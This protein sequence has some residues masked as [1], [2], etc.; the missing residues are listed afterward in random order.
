MMPSAECTGGQAGLYTQ[1]DNLPTQ[2]NP[3]GQTEVEILSADLEQARRHLHSLDS[4][5]KTFIFQTFDDSKD[6]KDPRLAQTFH[7][8]IDEHARILA[9]LNRQGAGIYVTVNC[10]RNGSRKK[11][12]I[13]AARAMYR[14][15]DTPDLPPLPVEPHLVIETSPGKKH[16]Y[17]MHEPTTDFESWEGILQTIVDEHGGDPGAKGRNRV[18]R[19]AGFHHMKDPLHPHQVKIIHKSGAGRITLDELAK[20]IPPARRNGS[21]T[22]DRILKQPKEPA[23]EM[24]AYAKAALN[25]E[26]ER[27]RLAPEGLRNGTLNQAAFSLGQ[28]VAGGEINTTTAKTALLDAAMAAGL[29]EGEAMRTIQS[30]MD[31][32]SKEPRLAPETNRKSYPIAAADFAGIEPARL[33]PSKAEMTPVAG[34]I[35]SAR[36]TP[37]CF[38]KNYIYADVATWAAPG[39]T[40]K[41][42]IS[43]YEAICLALKMPLHGMNIKKT[44]WTLFITAEDRREQ[45][46]ARIREMVNAMSL[47]PDLE[48]KVWEN[49]LIWDVTGEQQRLINL[50]DGNIILTD[51]ADNIVLAHKNDP[52]AL[53]IFDPAIS[54]GVSEG[55]VNDNENGIVLAC[56]RIVKGLD[57]CVRIIAHTGKANAREGT[58]DQYS[59]R[60][61]SALADGS[62]MV[63]VLQ[64]WLPGNPLRPPPDCTDDDDVSI[65]ILAR[66]KLSYSPPKLPNIWIRRKGWNIESFIDVKRDP[67]EIDRQ[68]Q[69]K[70]LQFLDEEV[71][72][73]KRH[74]KTTLET[75]VPNMSRAAARA[76]ITKLMVSGKITEADLPPGEQVTKKKTYL[77]T[78]A[79]FGRIGRIKR[80]RG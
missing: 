10:T 30:G 79:G 63:S 40:G 20:V 4:T 61:G 21:A 8:T 64:A 12:D 73:G 38:V 50:K 3:S 42:T 39:G 31:G 46:I 43:I 78:S 56:R 58:L 6:R 37:T 33:P 54:F 5:T 60:G 11:E 47:G 13:T 52:P 59:S 32:G 2:V 34:E 48:Q 7:G 72:A 75:V 18:L 26:V 57:C 77:V 70:V 15:A 36:L 62:R 45:L 69:E 55:F 27:V 67:E 14:E 17:I 44:G 29:P 66:P 28:L 76:A 53:V 22:A 41:T 25:S 9:R 68:G 23:G 35:S 51:M 74:S 19:L 1:L 16:E 71:A 49:V 80:G 65:V 24:S